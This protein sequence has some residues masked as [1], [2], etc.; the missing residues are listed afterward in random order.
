M[1]RLKGSIVP[2]VTPYN[3]DLSIDFVTFRKLIN[4]QIEN[5]SHGISVAGSTGEMTLL[6]YE[7]KVKLFE[8]AVQEASGKVPV[9]ASTGSS[10]LNETIAL[11]KEAEKIGCDALLIAV[12]YYSR[13]N[14][15]GIFEYFKKVSESVSLPIIIYNIPART[16]TNIEPKTLKKLKE[17]CKNIIGVKEANPNFDQMSKDIL[18]CGEDFLVYSGVESLCYP[19]LA[20]GGAGYLSATA[21]LLPKELA[22]LYELAK[23]GKWDEARKLHYKLLPI[24]EVLFIDTNPIPLKTAM[25]IL[26]MIKP[27]F[28]SPLVPLSEDKKAKLIEVLKLYFNI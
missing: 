5:G 1:E 3:E 19:L 15:E 16:G 20:I 18:E 2:L 12:P 22:K 13:P 27:I 4:W 28:R 21:N 26:G 7:E 8:V 9:V 24:N 6:S 25:G 14:Q 17:K 11:S 23:E 10:N